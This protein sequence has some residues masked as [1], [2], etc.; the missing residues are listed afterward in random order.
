MVNVLFV[1]HLLCETALRASNYTRVREC[2]RH[3][4]LVKLSPRE[5]VAF[6]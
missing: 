4:R 6:C 3:P 2:V 1:R 5:A